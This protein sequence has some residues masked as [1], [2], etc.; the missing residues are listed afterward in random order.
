MGEDKLDIC[1]DSRYW[2][3]RADHPFQP[4]CAVHDRLYSTMTGSRKE[5]DDLF[6]KH[7]LFIAGHNPIMKA[8]A[9]AM[10]GIVRSL[11]WIWWSLIN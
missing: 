10:Y 5:A 4:A 7:M 9:Y 1:G 2:G 6:L 8:Q 3:L 11:G